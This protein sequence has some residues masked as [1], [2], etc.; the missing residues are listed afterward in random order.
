MDFKTYF[1][2]SLTLQYHNRLNPKIW[3]KDDLAL[4]VRKKLLEIAKLWQKFAKIPDKAIKDIVLTGGNANY[5]YTDFSDLDVHLIVDKKE[6]SDCKDLL[7]DYLKDKKNLW[8]STHNIK[9]KDYSVELYAQD[10]NE[11]TPSNQGV[12]SLKKNKWLAKPKKECVNLKDPILAKK[13]TQY[14]NMIDHLISTKSDDKQKLESLK[15][16]LKNM[17]SSGLAKGGE[18]SIENLAF[19][20]LRNKGY[21]DKLSKYSMKVTDEKLSLD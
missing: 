11:T 17:R 6:I 18:F 16:R 13:I 8:S 3:D 10:L 9:I 1:N 2:E 5:N 15:D 21:I 19:K 14:K 4:D 12:F 20:E 7:D